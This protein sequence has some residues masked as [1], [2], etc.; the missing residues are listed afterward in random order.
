M[1][2]SQHPQSQ[3]LRRPAAQTGREFGV[4]DSR[5]VRLDQGSVNPPR[6][7]GLS[8]G[9]PLMRAHSAM[10]AVVMAETGRGRPL[11]PGRLTMWPSSPR[12]HSINPDAWRSAHPFQ[13]P[14]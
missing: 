5:D 12:T 11:A 7:S 9:I 14:P 10:P 4:N 13:T 6:A 1:A 8:D 3:S 2:A